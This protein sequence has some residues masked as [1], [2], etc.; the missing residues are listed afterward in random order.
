MAEFPN[1]HFYNTIPLRA[2]THHNT[3]YNL[4][5]GSGKWTIMGITLDK[6]QRLR[7]I[8]VLPAGGR[9]LDIGSSNLYAAEDTAIRQFAAAFNRELDEGLI[10]SLARGSVYGASSTKN[11]SFV[12]EPLES[13]GLTYLAFDI[14]DGYRTQAFDL[15]SETLSSKLRG[16]FDTVLNFGTTEHVINQPNAFRVIHDAV[17]IGGFI[18]H[19]LPTAGYIDH[20]YFYYTPRFF[21]DLAG[22]NQYDVVQ[23]SFA[24]GVTTSFS[25]GPSKPHCPASRLPTAAS[26]ACSLSRRGRRTPRPEASSST[27]IARPADELDWRSLY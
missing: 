3:P 22:Y 21:F 9:I 15:N 27:A 20:G 18:V 8:D 19:Q 25:A 2:S 14:A 26:A 10:Q 12:G 17:K 5:D 4:R 7:E 23:F 1:N 6:L 13:P 11:E 24:A 16:S